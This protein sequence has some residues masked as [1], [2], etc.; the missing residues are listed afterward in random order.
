M[1]HLCPNLNKISVE[2][3]FLSR[4]CPLAS[5]NHFEGGVV[6]LKRRALI[7][8]FDRTITVNN[9]FPN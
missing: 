6:L 7:A 3:S 8:Q 1:Y 9:F 4:L 2:D 5:E